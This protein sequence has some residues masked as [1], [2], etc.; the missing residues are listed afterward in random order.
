G[1]DEA[2][3]GE[4]AVEG[5]HSGHL[6]GNGCVFVLLAIPKVLD[7]EHNLLLGEVPHSVSEAGGLEERPELTEVIPVGRNGVVGGVLLDGEK[8]Q[9]LADAL[10]HTSLL[11][12][13]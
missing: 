7:V 10:V 3:G 1:I 13:C 5:L 12:Q 11:P 6:A 4:E 2:F 8:V 9:K